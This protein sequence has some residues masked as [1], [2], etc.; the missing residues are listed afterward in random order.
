MRKSTQRKLQ[1]TTMYL[2]GFEPEEVQASQQV[3]HVQAEV[4]NNPLFTVEN[5]PLE[6][7]VK[8]VPTVETYSLEPLAVSPAEEDFSGLGFAFD[9][10]EESIPVR[11]EWTRFEINTLVPPSGEIGMRLAN[12]S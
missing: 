4:A 5:G 1:D 2:P 9:P 10:G 6:V 11:K 8:A 3:V 12:P 7:Q